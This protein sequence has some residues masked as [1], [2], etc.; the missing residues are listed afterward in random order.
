MDMVAE[1]HSKPPIPGVIVLLSV[2]SNGAVAIGLNRG[3]GV[4]MVMKLVDEKP[5]QAAVEGVMGVEL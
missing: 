2:T 1:A 4:C 5:F 3:A